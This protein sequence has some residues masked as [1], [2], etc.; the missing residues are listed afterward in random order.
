MN[1]GAFTLI[2]KIGLVVFVVLALSACGGGGGTEGGGGGGE[3]AEQKEQAKA[4]AIPEEGKP[5]S[6]GKYVTTKF[7]RAFFPRRR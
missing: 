1:Q 4:S 5:L 6:P 2:L 7:K 3:Q